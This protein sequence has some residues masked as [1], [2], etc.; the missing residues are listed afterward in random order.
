[1]E[2]LESI[3]KKLNKPCKNAIYSAAEIA[4]SQKHYYVEIEHLLIEL[5]ADP[6]NEISYI[7]QKQNVGCE[8]VVNEL[9]QTIKKFEDDN[10]KPH[11]FFSH[12]LFLLFERTW[13]YT[14]LKLSSNIIS[15]GSILVTLLDNELLRENI[16]K[17]SSSLSKVAV[18][19][20]KDDFFNYIK[21]YSEDPVPIEDNSYE[22]TNESNTA[23]NKYTIDLT[24]KAKNGE[25]D[26]IH[27][28]NHEIE[29]II[30]II[31]KKRQNNPILTGEAGVGKTSIVEGLA[32]RI[33]KK[34]VP[35]ML[36]NVS[37][38]S[39][40]LTSLQAGAGV[41]GE[42]EKRLKSLINEITQSPYPI[43]LFIDETH[44]LIGAGGAA[45]TG[46]AAN[47]LK[48]GLARGELRVIGATTRSE[49]KQHIEKD[50]ALSRRF[51]TVD[52]E[53]PD[54]DSAINM[55][56]SMATGLEKHHDVIIMDEAIINSVKLT[57]R[58]V[59]ERKLPDKAVSVL[60]IA[61]SKVSIMQT[62][63]S[64]QLE[65]LKQK[66]EECKNEISFLKSEEISGKLNVEKINTLSQEYE[67][68]N[69]Q[70]QSEL[71][72]YEKTI[73][74]IKP[75]KQLH[76]KLQ[77]M[78]NDTS[79]YT[80]TI[81][82]YNKRKLTL[83]KNQNE[84]NK[85]S[86]YVDSKTVA[87]VISDL[88]DIPVEK[89]LYNDFKSIIN[90]QGAIENQIFGQTHAINDICKKIK[91]YWS[92]MND[93]KKPIGV[94]LLTGPPGVGKTETAKTLADIL[95]GSNRLIS[96][97]M[98][99]YQEEHSVANLKGSP[100]GYVGYG[101]GGILTEQVK[102]KPYSVLLL[103]EFEKAASKV[104]ELFYKIFDEGFVD[105]SDGKSINFTNT[106]IFLTSNLGENEIINYI[107]NTQ[108]INI[109]DLKKI[110]QP[111]LSKKFSQAMLDRMIVVPYLPLDKEIITKITHSK[112]E[113]I[114]QRL[115]ENY[116]ADLKID[117]NVL[118]AIENKYNITDSGARVIDY[119][120]NQTLL[121]ELS[122]A[123][124]HY[125]NEHKKAFS[126]VSVS[127]NEKNK[128]DFL[129]NK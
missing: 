56:R 83:L 116:N 11:P 43:I 79:D 102:H 126:S 60:D 32:L 108:D 77:L 58:Y 18:S 97:N 119:I 93:P 6:K 45:G 42:F 84:N 27:G 10:K 82:D 39:L 120:I 80:T 85:I 28:R 106:I 71:A 129:F 4:A 16:L 7:L 1:M 74:D 51:Q 128:L 48:P 111:A 64:F 78:K 17:S 2:M 34:N 31:N 19:S 44:T 103:D 109:S 50:D 72:Q 73:K 66:M 95:Y 88:T 52:V 22:K 29:Q 41:I 68:I 14:S 117:E 87:S 92:N 55:V 12:Y 67:L 20:F 115:S 46:D 15:S 8:I 40:D 69:K 90:L 123:I 47:L 122:E 86:L 112:I 54:E 5:L 33:I 62:S 101:T 107:N 53:E 23:L 121:P 114:K 35:P 89:I 57:H 9:K 124:F 104:I 37:L 38:L 26:Q 91:T 127:L 81:K 21:P 24:Q 110:M 36:Q 96:I 63:P 61:C 99:E 3:I 65:F 76:K 100:K 25:I 59:T 98:T 94:F 30:Q 105:D 75:I 113:K 13:I 125:M 118:K 70:Y 49:Y